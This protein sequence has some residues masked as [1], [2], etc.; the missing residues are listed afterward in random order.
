[1]RRTFWLLIATAFL[2]L[3]ASVT[4]W[5]STTTVVCSQG[6]VGPITGSTGWA[7]VYG[8]TI[9]A[10]SVAD[11]HGLR[12]TVAIA[13]NSGTSAQFRVQL[14]CCAPVD[15]SS[16][17]NYIPVIFHLTFMRSGSTGGSYVMKPDFARV[18]HRHS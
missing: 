2:Q 17:A 16:G 14:G 18:L 15:T 6:V 10:N 4:G 8:C 11:G 12:I 5:A 7:G 13:K 9:P 1:M 3:L